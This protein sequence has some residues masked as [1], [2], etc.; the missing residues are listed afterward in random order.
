MASN[1]EPSE[2][3]LSQI[4]D[5]GLKIFDDVSKS[6]EAT[7]SSTVQVSIISKRVLRWKCFGC[8]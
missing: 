3:K 5:D 6:M 4:F 8:G 7:N 1:D 2:K